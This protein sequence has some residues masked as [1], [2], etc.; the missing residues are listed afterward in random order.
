MTRIVSPYIQ[1]NTTV[2]YKYLVRQ[3]QYNYLI[4]YVFSPVATSGGAVCT[5]KEE[6][7]VRLPALH[8]G[9]IFADTNL[10]MLRSSVRSVSGRL[11]RGSCSPLARSTCPRGM[12]SNEPSSFKLYSAA[13]QHKQKR[14]YKNA[15]EETNKGVVSG[16][17]QQVL[18]R[19]SFC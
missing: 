12:I 15:A 17:F 16:L 5:L 18:T 14:S 3:V 10:T 11:F 8:R 4:Q 19:Q 9:R 13:L 1:V 6:L 7:L 2:E